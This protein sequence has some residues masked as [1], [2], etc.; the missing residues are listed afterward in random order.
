[1]PGARQ[2]L[3][4]AVPRE[5]TESPVTATKQ[6]NDRQTECRPKVIGAV[7]TVN[8]N[9]WTESKEAGAVKRGNQGRLL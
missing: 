9:D 6:M 1:M 2:A 7:V 8:Q 4:D 5:G 3:G